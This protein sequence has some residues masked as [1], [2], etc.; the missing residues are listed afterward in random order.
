MTPHPDN[1]SAAAM[2]ARHEASKL[3]KRLD[4]AIQAEEV[5]DVY[6][7]IAGREPVVARG[8]PKALYGLRSNVLAMTTLSGAGVRIDVQRIQRI[9]EVSE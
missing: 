4:D 2:P 7:G 8:L 3:R 5:V 6:H 9:E 1:T